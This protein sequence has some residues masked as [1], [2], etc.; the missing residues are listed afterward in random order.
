M[1]ILLVAGCGGEGDPCTIGMRADDCGFGLYCSGDFGMTGTCRCSNLDYTI[2]EGEECVAPDDCQRCETDLTCNRGSNA[3][4]VPGSAL[5]GE[6]CGEDA[7][8]ALGT[9][10]NSQTGRCTVIESGAVGDAC[11]ATREC[12]IGLSC[13]DGECWVPQGVGATCSRDDQC[14]PGLFCGNPLEPTICVAPGQRGELCSGSDRCAE[15]LICDDY[16]YPRQCN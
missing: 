16:Y 4:Q 12:S 6:E 10:C 14:A 11:G 7:D 9:V 13:I 2:R 8:C 15:G 5:D 3:C 1:V